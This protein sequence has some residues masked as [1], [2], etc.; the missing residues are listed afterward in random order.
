MNEFRLFRRA[1]CLLAAA[2]LSIGAPVSRGAAEKAGY[3]EDVT[4][5][6]VLSVA[7]G[8]NNLKKLKDRSY[9]TYWSSA[10]GDRAWIEVRLPKN[11]TGSGV[12]IQWHE[13]PHAWS[14]QLK[15]ASGIW[16][17]TDH[18]EG[19]FLSEFLFLPEGTEEFRIA[20]AAGTAARMRIAELRVY[21]SGEIPPEVQ[22]W[23]PPAAK[24]DL[25]LLAAHP[26]DEILWFG[27]TLP[28]YAGEQNRICQVCM[29]VPTLP[30]RRLEL[31]DGLW[32]CGVRTYP[33]WGNFSNRFTNSLSKQ[34]TYWSRDRVYRQVTEWIRRFQP[35][36]LLTHDLR[37]EYGHGAHRVCADAA[38]H[39]LSA[40][41]NEQKYRDSAKEYGT[42]DVPKCYLHLYDK[43]KV[44]MDW[45][46]PLEAFGGQ[47]ALDVAKAAFRC[48]VS[49]RKSRYHVE[50]FGA[51][52]CRLFGLYR[53]LAG[54]DTG[55]NDFFENLD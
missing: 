52:D 23:D 9:T 48:H 55:L 50:D 51:G 5:R 39:C 6:C 47:T 4:G 25:M 24:A 18:T 32:T 19:T 22:R 45:N 26:D 33:V 13:H 11:E 46:V 31:L 27:G 10:A 14:I 28:L 41:A 3:A 17:E 30:C 15:N 29:L 53:S 2:L 7:S 1:L 16:E 42:W 44:V 54:E 34:Y 21:G 43:G 37:G 12:W 38:T 40:A 8:K 35:Q 49:Q 36:V 20:G